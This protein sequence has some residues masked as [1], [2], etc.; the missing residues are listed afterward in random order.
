MI[1]D[2]LKDTWIMIPLLYITYCVLEIFERKDSSDDSM[3]YSLQK[4]GPLFGAI[5][6]LIPQC[7]FSILAAM[8]FLQK[9]ITL[10]TLI[11]VMIAT[12]DEAIPVLISNPHLFSSLIALLVCKFVIA[13]VVGYFVDFVLIK[14]QSIIHFEDMEEQEDEVEEDTNNACPCC[15][16]QYPLYISAALR[17]LKIY[18]FIFITSLLISLC[19]EWIGIDALET[20]LLSHSIFQPFITALFGF[21]PNCAITVVLAQL[22]T[23]SGISFG[24]LLAGLITNAGLGLV[25]L[26]RYGASKK[27]IFQTCAILY[28]TAVL[29]GMIC[30]LI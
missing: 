3:F 13:L 4:Y 1:L 11:A 12:S 23:I 20:I 17:T 7:G 5:L 15:Y 16:I 18:G 19:I 30:I 21:I 27:Q 6:G 10:G 24:S 9:N 29:S 25:C 2:I 8:L 26:I 28:I 22:Y 14:K